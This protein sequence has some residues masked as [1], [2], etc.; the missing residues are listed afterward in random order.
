MNPLLTVKEAVTFTGKSE[1]TIKR[2]LREVAADVEHP[3]RQF[4]LPSHDE[5]EKRRAAGEPYV[6]KIDKELLERRYPKE[7]AAE[8]GSP[9]SASNGS[10]GATGEAIVAVLREQLQS[11]DRQ[12]ETL[13]KQLD[14]KDEQIGNQN[15]R[16]REQNILMKDLQQRLSIAAPASPADITVESRDQQGRE[17]GRNEK[18]SDSNR[19]ASIW[20]RQFRLFGRRNA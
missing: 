6:W 7:T 5:V 4:I 20:S 15:E 17:T 16:M 11:K 19:K 8:E 9:A 12:I 13:E 10:L 1:S 3:D 2:L 14:K 18:S